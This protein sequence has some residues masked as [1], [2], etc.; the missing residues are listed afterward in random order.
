MVPVVLLMASAATASMAVRFLTPLAAGIVADP[1]NI[2][3]LAGAVDRP[4]SDF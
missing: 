3:N 1:N 2:G 4:L